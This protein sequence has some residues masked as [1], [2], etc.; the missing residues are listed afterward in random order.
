ML[1]TAELA[2]RLRE[3]EAE[4]ARTA[5]RLR[6]LES[7]T[8]VQVAQVLI[9]GAKDPRRAP[10]TVPRELVGLGRRWRAR[11]ARRTATPLDP[12][13]PPPVP[14]AAG[15]QLGARL[16]EGYARVAV[17]R[18]RPVVAGILAQESADLLRPAVHLTRLRPDDAEA[19]LGAV[20]PEVLL[21][22]AGAAVLGP[23]AHLGTF[24]APER[25]RT[26]LALLRAASAGGATTVLWASTGWDE[27][28]PLFDRV[29]AS[30][31]PAELLAVLEQ[32]AS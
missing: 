8:A 13:P 24:A 5:A 27:L 30:E 22:D 23:W 32:A 26:L 19:V 9:A 2:R 15:D 7:S 4:L 6:R 18:T 16:L 29:V 25:D 20:A 31:D 3:T 12:P 17:P 1:A 21:V 14:A 11:G 28:A 10:L